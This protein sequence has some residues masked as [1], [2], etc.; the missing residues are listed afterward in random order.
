MTDS[1][2]T[3]WEKGK[4]HKYGL[5]DPNTLESGDKIKRG[6]MVNFKI[7][8]KTTM[9]VSGLTTE[10]MVLGNLLTKMGRSTR[11]N[12]ST[13]SSMARGRRPGKMAA[14]MK[15][16]II[17]ESKKV[18]ESLQWSTKMYMRG[19]GKTIFSMGKEPWQQQIIASTQVNGRKVKWM[20]GES[21]LGQ[22]V[23]LMMV[24]IKMI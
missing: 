8:S 5:T 7:S 12:G 4:E 6:D 10:H 13:M 16:L 15:E 18:M 11:V 17:T 24:N 2:K 14:S 22:Q 23:S 3:T 19:F 20:E 21:T 1:S 9:K